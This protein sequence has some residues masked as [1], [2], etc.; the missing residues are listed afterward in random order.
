MIGNRL[1]IDV[2]GGPIQVDDVSGN[3][4][5]EERGA[6]VADPRAELVDVDVRVALDVF[7]RC[8]ELV[9]HDVGDREPRMRDLHQDGSGAALW[10]REVE[11]DRHDNRLAP[12]FAVV[13]R[14]MVGRP[15]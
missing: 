14:E 2:V 5:G 1:S 13:D 6:D 15:R 12:E 3:P 7:L 9:A 4:R 11:E 8:A 10:H